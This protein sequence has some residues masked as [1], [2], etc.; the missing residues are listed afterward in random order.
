MTT[1]IARPYVAAAFEFALEK[2]DLSAW[3]TMLQAAGDL[4]TDAS[5]RKLLQNPKVTSEQL[6]DL[7]CEALKPFLDTNKTNFIRLLAENH[8]LAMLPE[9]TELFKAARA[10]NEKTLVAQVS[11]AT[12]LSKSYQEKLA[13]ALTKRLQRTVE[14]QFEINPDL[15][16]GAIVR[17][18]DLVIDGSVSGKLT[19]LKDF[20]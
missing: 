16:G 10:D 3:E 1:T 12:K 8:R 11:S 17:A 14:L 9:I 5:I 15:V 7:F 18:G 20:I 2:K 13:K 6:A 19:R 4:A